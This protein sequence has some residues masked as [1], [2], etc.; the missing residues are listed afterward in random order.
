M[1]IPIFTPKLSIWSTKKYK[2]NYDKFAA[3]LQQKSI[4]M[5]EAAFNAFLDK[6]DCKQL[7]KDP[8]YIAGKSFYEIWIKLTA[9]SGEM[10]EKISKG[11]RLFVRGL[12]EMQPE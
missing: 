3:G 4:F 9:Y 8:V 1:S 2:G 11:D 6:P 7:A 12:M 5:D 10:Q